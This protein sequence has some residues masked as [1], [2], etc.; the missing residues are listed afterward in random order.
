MAA[1]YFHI[2]FCKRICAYCDFHRFADLSAMNA[3]V[4][5]MH[6]ELDESTD[7]LHDRV[8][9][10]IYFG[11]GTPS[12]LAPAE[13]QRF[14]DHIGRLYDT[15]EV[16]EITVEANPDDITPQFVN[17]LKQ[18]AVNRISL[19][20][21]SFDERLLK[22]MNRRH[23]GEEA[24]QAVRT[25]QNAGYQNITVDLI[26]GFGDFG[27][28]VVAEDLRRI[29]ELEIQHVSAYHLTIE[30]TTRLGR[31]A[32]QGRFA[33]IPEE[34]SEKQFRLIHNTLTELGFEHYEVSN[35]ARAGFRSRHNSS[36]WTGTEYLGIGTGAHSFNS[37]SRRWCLQR[38]AEY[39]RSR[40]Y[41]S[42]TLTPRDHLNEMIMTSLRRAEGLDTQAVA[43][44]FGREAADRLL[45][46]AQ[47]LS[48]Y[49]AVVENCHIRIPP[50]HMLTSDAVIEMLFET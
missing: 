17:E 24:R 26:F 47:K 44:R 27:D 1:I 46:E 35:Y 9:K 10:T 13:L 25:L 5:A 11:G 15:S 14:I 6:D 38:P 18:T 19:G 33:A 30:P 42:E 7:F 48:G 49:G 3:V 23:T 2:P 43:R 37:E 40:A 32:A 45:N 21:Q 41:E 16:E 22:L 34:R 50:E 36:Y 8:I 29:A 39:L 31:M 4:A 20:I 12:L 28:E